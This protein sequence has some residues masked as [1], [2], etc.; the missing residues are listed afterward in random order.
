VQAAVDGLPAGSTIRI[1][2]GTYGAITVS[3]NVTLIGAGDGDDPASNTILDAANHGLVVT[4]ASGVTASLQGLRITGGHYFLGGGIYNQGDLTVSACTIAG[5]IADISGGGIYN[6]ENLTV[7][8]CTIMG[9]TASD[10]GGIFQYQDGTLTLDH[11]HVL[12]NFAS[13]GG[14][15]Y[16]FFGT[17]TFLDAT[18][19]VKNNTGGGGIFNNGTIT[20]NGTPVTDN[21]PYNC[22]GQ[23]P[24]TGCSG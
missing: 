12:A 18:G 20:L 21:T 1:C 24:I 10:G 15:I 13:R 14:G 11:T 9:N 23:V 19:S 17:V 3:K 16:V 2:A 4:I 5:N 22:A 6:Q 7:S 8:A